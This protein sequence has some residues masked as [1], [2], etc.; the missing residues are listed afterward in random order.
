MMGIL[1]NMYWAQVG[2]N[3][4]VDLEDQE[5]DA[6]NGVRS[7]Y[8]GRKCPLSPTASEQVAIALENDVSMVHA[9]MPS[10]PPKNGLQGCRPHTPC[11]VLVC[12]TP[13]RSVPRSRS[14]LTGGRA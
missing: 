3:A 6:M 8:A 10:I 1:C 12:S 7:L 14:L 13:L 9:S 2:V 5:L 11:H 4:F